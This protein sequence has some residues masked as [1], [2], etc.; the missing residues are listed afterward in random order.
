MRF[1]LDEHV[2]PAIA[3]GLRR[4]GVDV[5]TTRDA[6]LISASDERHLE[7][8]LKEA[9]VIFTN[10]S[11]FVSFASANSDHAGIAYCDRDTRSIGEII[12]YLCLMHDCMEPDEMRGKVEFI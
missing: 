4:L 3:D 11:G 5:T 1:H 7:F 8:A 10:D 6:D 12:R 2:S 9:R